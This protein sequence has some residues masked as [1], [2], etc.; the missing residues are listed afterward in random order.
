MPLPTH[1]DN[2]PIRY[3][4]SEECL[5]CGGK[6]IYEQ[7]DVYAFE[8]CTGSCCHEQTVLLEE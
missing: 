7:N 3:L 8:R 1:E 5:D 4:D 2:G 6:I